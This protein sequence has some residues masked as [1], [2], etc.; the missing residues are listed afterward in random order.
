MTQP[1]QTESAA[2][3]DITNV[4]GIDHSSQTVHA[5]VTVLTGKNA[6][7][8]TSF[9]QAVMA[10]CGSDQAT[11]KA[12]AE[13]GEV[14]L[15]LDGTEYTRTLTRSGGTVSFGGEPYLDDS[16]IADAFAFLLEDNEARRAV[17]RGD[18]LREII[19][20]P[21]D[22]DEIERDIERLQSE[23]DDVDARLD[24]LDSLAD[25]LPE[26]RADRQRLEAEIDEKEAELASTESEMAALDTSFQ[27]T[28]EEKEAYEAK[29]DALSQARQERERLTRRIESERDSLESLETDREELTAELDEYERVSDGRLTEIDEE[30]QR[31]RGR[32]QQIDSTVGDLQSVIQFNEEFVDGEPPAALR[33]LDGT[34]Q[35]GGGEL[36]DQL[37]DDSTDV[38][39]WTCGSTVELSQVEATLDRLR[40]VR[41]EQMD[42]RQTIQGRVDALQDERSTLETERRQRERAERKL[43]EVEA[44]IDDRESTVEDLIEQR[45]ETDDEIERLEAEVDELEDVKQSDVLDLQKVTSRL[46]VEIERRSD[47]LADVEDRI[48]EL[49]SEL[50]EREALERRREQLSTEL[51]ALRT[52]IEDLQT[53]AIEA[54]NSHMEAVLERLGYENLERIWIER[55]ETQVREG[56]RKVTAD[57]FDLHVVRST[58]SGT[59]YEDTVDHLSESEREIT[60]LVFALAG[61]LV[62]EV[63]DRV[64]FMLLDSIEAVDADRI[65]R[66]VDYL[67]EYSDYLVVALLEEDAQALDDDYPR[68]ESI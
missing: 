29:L 50:D 11:L 59:V 15:T 49:E 33:S 32:M 13:A 10:V 57:Q 14:S 24:R 68:V 42:E 48:A 61:Y 26:L 23:R 37:V 1:R 38:T 67:A 6:T 21:V 3:F 66:L 56:R 7:N 44:E 31:L 4:G 5:G 25:E 55:T 17:A 30:I 9:L 19:M 58:D 39:C 18:D 63:Y 35:S 54:F 28:R 47:D 41:N 43:A 64:P 22:T 60:G 51:A 52:R 45:T 16:L 27:E 40:Q 46:E 2:T 36:T 20:R 34:E 12:D 65:A 53:D 8:R 62:H